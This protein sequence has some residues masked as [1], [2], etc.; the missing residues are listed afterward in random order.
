MNARKLNATFIAIIVVVSG[1]FGSLMMVPGLRELEKRREA[2]GAE[3]NET[4]QIQAVVAD[5]S[6]LYAEILRVRGRDLTLWEQ[7]PA[8]PRFSEFLNGLSRCLSAG[9]ITKYDVQ[10]QLA[11][12]IDATKLPESLN[13]IGQIAVQPVELKFD[14]EF[15]QVF[16]LLAEMERLNRLIHVD[17]LQMTCDDKNAETLHVELVLQA[18]YRRPA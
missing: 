8:E 13:L 2:I 9:G 3:L 6:S 11:R 4:K 14:A 1:A 5:M 7:V 18:Y 16:E 15:K 12:E 17:R 10:P